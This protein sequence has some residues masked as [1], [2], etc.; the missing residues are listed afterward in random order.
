MDFSLTKEQLALK[1]E[2]IAFAKEQLNVGLVKR[3]KEQIFDRSLWEKCGEHLIP[4]L[5]IP[6]KYGG[7]GSDPVELAVALEGLG[8]GCEDGGLCFALCAHLLACVIPIW[9]HGS[10]EQKLELLPSLSNGT[11]IAANAM[12][13]ASGGSDVYNM[14]TTAVED[15]NGFRLNGKKVFCSN[16]PVADLVLTYAMTDREKGFF[17]GITAFL[18]NKNQHDFHCTEKVDKVGVRTCMMGDV[19]Y[20]DLEV[21]PS[22][23]LGEVG[24]GGVIFTES[25]N[26]ERALLGACHL[27]AMERLLERGIQFVNQR[28][29]GVQTIS[30][31]QAI[32]HQ[33]ADMRVNL[34]AARLLTYQAAWDLSQGNKVNTTAA[35]SKLYVSETFKEMTIKMM[36]I[37][38]GAAYRGSHE[39][40]RLLRDALGSTIY[41]GTS[42]I[43]RNLI[44]RQMRIKC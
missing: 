9:K 17:G 32:A 42:E 21:S 40:E 22:F 13:E 36:Q 33:L 15:G 11:L 2:M 35:I 7:R 39:A 38:G 8:Y 5:G 27:G 10:E 16:A 37:F 6:A 3:D 24:G 26:W 25:M 44:A 29:S 43:Q 1:E 20:D 14:K 41:S 31:H 30:Q 34:N 4:G 28:K 18:L 23:V 19:N 12:T